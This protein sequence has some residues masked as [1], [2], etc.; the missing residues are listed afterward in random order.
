MLAFKKKQCYFEL[1]SIISTGNQ[2]NLQSIV[3]W[4]DKGNDYEKV[5]TF[6]KWQILRTRI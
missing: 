5:L 2:I 1:V 6:H 3:L 4:L